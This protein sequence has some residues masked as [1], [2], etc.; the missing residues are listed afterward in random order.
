MIPRILP[1]LLTIAAA[2]MLASCG[3]D[4]ASGGSGGH[5][6][7]QG[8]HD[9]ALIDV[10]AGTAHVEFLHDNKAGTV[11][12]YVTGKD[13]KTP[14][15]LT[16]APELHLETDKGPK[17]VN[18]EPVDGAADGASQFSVTDPLLK[19]DPL[20][21]RIALKF[22]GKTYNPEIQEGHDH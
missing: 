7:A 1:R 3:D 11:T 17:V 9:G 4:A 18:T 22:G 15:K 8:A 19:M 2:C 13:A 5:A 12:L 20:K 10:G 6:H 21:G 16:F 14:M